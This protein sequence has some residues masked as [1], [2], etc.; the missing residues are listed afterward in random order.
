MSYYPIVIVT[1]PMLPF[2][3]NPVPVTGSKPNNSLELASPVSTL[4]SYKVCGSIVDT[5]FI[6]NCG[7][8]GS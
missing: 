7:C 6:S 1:L 8:S 5:R 2:I 4:A 3:I